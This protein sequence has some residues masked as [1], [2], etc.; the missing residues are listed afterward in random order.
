M[1]GRRRAA[2]G[3]AASRRLCA[4]CRRTL[5]AAGLRLPPES[6]PLA[7]A[8]GERS[9]CQRPLPGLCRARSPLWKLSVEKGGLCRQVCWLAGS[10]CP[11]LAGSGSRD[12]ALPPLGSP[13]RALAALGVADGFHL[14]G[15]RLP[16]LVHTISPRPGACVLAFSWG[17]GWLPGE[18]ELRR[19]F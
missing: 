5:A 14:P 4:G 19:W 9:G 1:S 12:A 6:A 16:L 18:F 11:A 8:L 10:A 15:L 3:R 7:A 2:R 13:G 17:A